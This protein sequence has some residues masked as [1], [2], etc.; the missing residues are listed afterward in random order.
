M[1]FP[2]WVCA[3]L[4]G[5]LLAGCSSTDI[6]TKKQMETEARLEQILQSGSAHGAQLADLS[7]ELVEMKTR[8]AAQETAINGIKTEL[9]A[10]RQPPFAYPAAVSPP[11]NSATIEVVNS[12]PP[13][14]DHEAKQQEAYMKAFGIFSANRYHEAITAFASFIAAYPESEYAANAQYWI[15]ECHYTQKE[16]QKALEAFNAVL[17]RYPKGKKVPDAM[18]KVA[19]SQMSLNDQPSARATLQKLIDTYPK[20]PAAAKARERMNRQ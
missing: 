14:S 13:R 12:E 9:T 8:L 17:L 4:A 20:S 3:G 7:R 2:Q 10:I 1:H 5:L 16:Y 6:I 15:G 18:L 11:K 19:F